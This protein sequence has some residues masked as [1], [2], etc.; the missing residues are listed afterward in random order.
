MAPIQGGGGGGSGGGDAASAYAEVKPAADPSDAA[1][2]WRSEKLKDFVWRA[3]CM[4]ID[5]DPEVL[6]G[7]AL[8][9]TLFC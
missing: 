5:Q 7:L 2:E 4:G 9:T 6:V 1:A 8:F 3:K